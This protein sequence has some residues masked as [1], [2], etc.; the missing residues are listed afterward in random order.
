MKIEDLKIIFYGSTDFSASVLKG[1]IQAGAEVVGV[2][3]MPDR[4]VR[5]RGKDVVLPN[6]VKDLALEKKLT[7]LQ[8]EDIK[9]QEFMKELY[10]LKPNLQIVVAFKILPE[11][12]FEFPEF[13][14]INLH[15]SFLPAYRG[16]APIPWAIASGETETGI[17]A[18]YLDKRVDSGNIL[19]QTEPYPVGH[20]TGQEIYDRFKDIARLFIF[21]VLKAVVESDG[22]PEVIE[23]KGEA[24]KA[25]KLTRENTALGVWTA[26]KTR[27]FIQGVSIGD[28]SA[29]CEFPRGQELKILRAGEVKENLGQTDIVGKFFLY[30][31]SIYLHCLDGKEVK[32]L[33]VQPSGKK[34]MDARSWWNGLR[35]GDK[36]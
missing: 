4:A 6:E 23:Q 24:S 11:S 21:K 27:C 1:I 12:V 28:H 7:I 10:R 19:L 25:P 3:T 5:K 31:K 17:T 26:E 20:S 13:G 16:A 2:V 36:E 32:I 29:W 35:A 15:P 8:P 30:Q 33:E 34:L 22:H 14:T 18:F 9:S